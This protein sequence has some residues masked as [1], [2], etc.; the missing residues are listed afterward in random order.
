MRFIDFEKPIIDLQKKID[1]LS[2]YAQ[3]HEL[4]LSS[5]IEPLQKALEAKEKEIFSGLAPYQR[6][7]L[8]RHPE[9]PYMMDFIRRIFDDFIEMHGDRNFRDDPAIVAGLASLDGRPVALAGH[10]KGRDTEENIRRN[11]GMAH[12]EG[13]RKALRVM[14]TAERFQLPIICFIDA[15]GAYPGIG[16]EERG[17]SEAIARN[18]LEMSQFKT[19]II[20]VV[21][22]EGGS[23]GALAI[24][25]GDRVL[26]FE[27]AYYAVCTPEACAAI[28]WKD[29]SKA[30]E[31]TPAMKIMPPDLKRLGV[32]DEI[33]SEPFGGAHRDPDTMAK[34]LKKTL[35]KHLKELDKIPLEQ[36]PDERYDKFRKM[37]MFVKESAAS[38]NAGAA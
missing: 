9:R 34:T 35:L 23:G 17:Q 2:R 37:G 31:A 11:F 22:G 32:V 19:P 15:A 12:P 29:G 38:D 25:I 28:I 33:I 20:V 4:D 7:K 21:T 1:D 36:L 10:Q 16:A 26:I 6:I 24:G 27:N 30:A 14:Q 3:E 5:E 8:A 18:L 13:F